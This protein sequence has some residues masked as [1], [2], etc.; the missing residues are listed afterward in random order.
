MSVYL[1]FDVIE[2]HTH[3]YFMHTCIQHQQTL[4]TQMS[5]SEQTREVPFR[6]N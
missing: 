5:G 4:Y 3:T 6:E 2:L 1:N